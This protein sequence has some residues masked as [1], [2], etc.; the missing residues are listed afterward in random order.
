ME[1]YKLEIKKDGLI[2]GGKPF[3]LASGDMHYFRILPGGWKK[4]LGLMKDFGLTAVQTYVPWNLHEP[5]EGVFDFAGRL[6]LAAFLELAHDT[7]L[8]VMLRPAPFICSEWDFGGLPWW[9]LKKKDAEVRCMDPDYIVAM[10]YYYRRLCKEFTPYLSTRGGPVIAVAIENE[11]GG[12]GSDNEYLAKIRKCLEENCVD[13]PFYTT[14]GIYD[15]A[16][17]TLPGVWEGINYRTESTKAIAHLRNFQPDLPAFVGEYWSGRS[18]HWDEI[19]RH[20]D[21]G[22]VAEAYKIALEEGAYVNFYMFAGGTNFGFMN[23]ANHGFAFT[24]KPDSYE[25]YIPM[26]TS[27][28]ADAPINEYGEPTEKYFACRAVLDE[29]LGKP[30]RKTEL[31]Q[32]PGRNRPVPANAQKIENV[33]MTEAAPLFEKLGIKSLASAAGEAGAAGAATVAPG[34]AASVA[35]ASGTAGMAVATEDLAATVAPGVAASVVKSVKLRCMEELGQGHG[36][37]LYSTS[38]PAPFLSVPRKLEI[39]GLADRATIYLDG[40]YQGKYMRDRKDEAPVMVTVPAGGARL[41][42]LVENFGRINGGRLLKDRKGITGCVKI[43]SVILYNWTIYTLDM[44][45]LSGL[46]W[47]SIPAG[48]NSADPRPAFYRGRFRAKAG[49][50][51]FLRLDGWKKGIAWVNG[52]NLGRYWETGP[53][54]TLYVPGELLV[55]GEDNEA[56]VFEIH[57]PPP[58]A[59]VSF[60]DIHVLDGEIRAETV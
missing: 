11:Y 54:E 7:G 16:Y 34:A 21:V 57:S 41:D 5:E 24:R 30:V 53:Q 3:Y 22:P 52:F 6:D 27:Y 36:F 46:Q 18:M 40:V 29:Y 15:L 26:T 56:V 8:K 19:F 12:Y 50:D 25:K 58:E 20:R 4:R 38:V 14:D 44:K 43:G 33:A 10:S 59:K 31:R 55:D 45:D 28:D 17:G 49:A 51:T 1:P 35:E 37:I 2:L 39:F 47:N 9:L 23:G 13:V 60:D 48:K 42:I 32:L